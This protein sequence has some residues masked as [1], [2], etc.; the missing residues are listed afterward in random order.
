[1][2]NKCIEADISNEASRGLQVLIFKKAKERKSFVF[3]ELDL[4][5]KDIFTLQTHRILFLIQVTFLMFFLN[6]LKM[7]VDLSFR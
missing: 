2:H 7:K 4:P 3:N 5:A 6:W 1:M